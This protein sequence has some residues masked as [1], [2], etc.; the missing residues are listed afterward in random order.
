[1]VTSPANISLLGDRVFFSANDGVHGRELWLTRG[2]AESTTLVKD[3][4]YGPASSNPELLTAVGDTIYFRAEAV[5]KGVELFMSD[6]TPDGTHMLRDQVQGPGSSQ[7]TD[8]AAFRD[9]LVFSAKSAA[10]GRPLNEPELYWTD[11]VQVDDIAPVAETPGIFPR[12]MTVVGD[13]LFFTADD[14]E[15]GRELWSVTY[16][17]IMKGGNRTLVRDLLPPDYSISAVR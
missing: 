15:L 2:D 4:F 6:G 9:V 13:I 8:L 14:Q 12:E 7:P 17:E 3:L 16:D 11:G 1:M 5:R 10:D